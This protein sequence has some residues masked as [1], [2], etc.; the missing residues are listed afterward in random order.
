MGLFDKLGK[1]K[2]DNDL[3]QMLE[4]AVKAAFET[5]LK[6]HD[7]TYYY[8][9]LITDEEGNCPFISAWS[10]EALQKILQENDVTSEDEKLE[11]KWSYADSPYCAYGWEDYFTEINDMV[12]ERKNIYEEDD[13]LD[14]WL[15][16]LLDYMEK[17]MKNLDKQGV[18]GVGEKRNQ[19][20]INAEVMPPDYGNTLRALRLNKKENLCEWLEEIAEEE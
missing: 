8:C 3:K 7:E 2:E 9:S 17:V 12:E 20:V 11:Y 4:N 14:E 10:R 5:L 18:F 16:L 13:R 1:R 6:E 15:E 19:I